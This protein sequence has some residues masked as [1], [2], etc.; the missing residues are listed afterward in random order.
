VTL[1]IPA[2]LGIG[3]KILLEKSI[4]KNI[5]GIFIDERVDNS[6]T[7]NSFINRRQFED[8]IIKNRD[9]RVLKNQNGVIIFLYS[10]PDKNTLVITTTPDVYEEI[11]DRLLT[12]RLAR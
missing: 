4:Q 5:G 10:F 3:W 8:A 11:N 6:S 7:T 1:S 12:D 2:N 9:A